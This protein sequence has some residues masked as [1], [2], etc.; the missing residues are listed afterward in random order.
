MLLGKGSLPYLYLVPPAAW[1]EIFPVGGK[2]ANIWL[3]EGTSPI[4]PTRENPG[5]VMKVLKAILFFVT[6]KKTNKKGIEALHETFFNFSKSQ[7][8]LDPLF[9]NKQP[10]FLL[11][12][13]FEEHLNPQVTHPNPSGLTS[14]IHSL[15][16][17]QTPEGFISLKNNHLIFSQTF[18]SHHDWE[19]FQVHGGQITGK[20][21]CNSKKKLRIF[22]YTHRQNFS[23]GSYHHPHRLREITHPP[24]SIFSKIYFHQQKLGSKLCE[25]YLGWK[26]KKIAN[27]FNL[28]PQQSVFPL[29]R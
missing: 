19:N 16:F 18:I 24:N 5:R 7:R 28:T 9:Q 22:P 4:T 13:F 3:M 27:F 10:L 17:L 2:W 1:G 21:I 15:I 12:L 11:P 8:Y 20:C 6:K 14:R 25:C 23:P 29:E 26:F